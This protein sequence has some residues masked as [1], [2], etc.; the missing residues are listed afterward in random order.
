MSSAGP[1][2]LLARPLFVRPAAAVVAALVV[3]G[4]AAVVLSR[5]SPAAFI[6]AGLVI[7]GV[8]GYA[9][10]RWPRA[11]LVGVML[12]PILDRYLIAGLIPSQLADTTHY[13]SEGLLATAAAVV[14]VRGWRAGTL[15]PALRHPTVL[16]LA[17]FVALLALSATLNDVPPLQ[18]AVGIG[19]TVDAALL[20]VLVRVVGLS[21]RQALTAVAVF[22]AVIGAAAVVAMVQAVLSPEVLGLRVLAGRFGEVYRLASFFGDPNAFGAF[23]AAAVPF[24]LFGIT[25]LPTRGGRRVALALSFLL[26]VALWL[27]FS[28]GSWLALLLG[29]AFVG[30]VIDFRALRIGLLLMVLAFGAALVMPRDLLGPPAGGGQERPDLIGSTIG[31]LD[32][33]GA[34]RD[35]RTLF[36]LNAVPIVAD[37]PLLGVGPG[38][39]GGAGAN[40][41]GTPVYAEYGTD[42]LLTDETQRTVDNFWLHL[43]VESGLLGT[44]AFAAAIGVVFFPLLRVARRSGGRRGVLLAG[45]CGAVAVLTVDSGTTMLLEANSVGFV[46][47]FLLGIASL[48]LASGDHLP[49]GAQDDPDVEPE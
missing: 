42:R 15:V 30:A 9:A 43:G 14:S 39:Y 17:A 12:S 8:V 37:H 29:W 3:L 2:G 25:R 38:R 26:L 24:T 47:W 41:F 49:Q 19:F 1:T 6:G 7:L 36:V 46:Y 22:L 32:T 16:A 28:R 13:L 20:F 33:V 31:R 23:L 34:G 5:V 11:V 45:I 40:L 44:A 4:L 27:S 18:A 21:G 48:E 10:A 35:L